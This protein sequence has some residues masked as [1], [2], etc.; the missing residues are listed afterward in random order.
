[1]SQIKSGRKF[2][3]KRRVSP[4]L[5]MAQRVAQALRKDF[6]K[7]TSAVKQIA[8][9]TMANV[10]T[11]TNWY[12]GKNMPGARYLL[13]LA[14]SSPSVLKI[15]LTEI[16]GDELWEAFQLSTRQPRR[17]T[18]RQLSLKYRSVEIGNRHSDIAN[19]T[20]ATALNERQKWLLTEMRRGVRPS[21]KEVASTW[22]VSV[23]TAFRDFILMHDI[24]SMRRP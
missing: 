11:A 2:G 14:R 10:D 16:G 3:P 17:T 15:V 4:D 20:D 13:S 1:M 7:M 23:R 21:A 5:E 22:Q 12:Q 8:Q 24:L 18:V 6:G 9:M 19:V